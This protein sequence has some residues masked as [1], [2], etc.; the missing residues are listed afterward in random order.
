MTV[1]KVVQTE[2]VRTE[3][4]T[5]NGVSEHQDF[6]HAPKLPSDSPLRPT[7]DSSVI[8]K[9]I[10]ISPTQKVGQCHARPFSLGLFHFRV[11]PITF[12]VQKSPENKVYFVPKRQKTIRKWSLRCK[13][14][15]ASLLKSLERERQKRGRGSKT[16]EGDGATSIHI[17]CPIKRRQVGS[18]LHYMTLDVMMV[19]YC[20][21]FEPPKN[22]A[23]G[24]VVS[25]GLNADLCSDKKVSRDRV[26]F[27]R[28]EYKPYKR[29]DMKPE[30]ERRKANQSKIKEMSP[31]TL[32]HW[33]T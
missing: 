5:R 28:E 23:D 12:L 21:S 11:V 10:L 13:Y 32:V 24:T 14:F 20:C 1:L 8:K 6:K 27:V 22:M 3:Q 17:I 19:I 33:I 18:V 4:N 16:I 30:F 29:K 7:S 25:D 15:P 31:M 26:D 9:I 2:I